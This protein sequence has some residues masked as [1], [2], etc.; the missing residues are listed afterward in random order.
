MDNLLYIVVLFIV[1]MVIAFSASWVYSRYFSK[2]PKSAS[3]AR[4]EAPPA[5]IHGQNLEPDTEYCHLQA[6]YNY[7]PNMKGARVSVTHFDTENRQHEV[8]AEDMIEGKF[9]QLRKQLQ[10]EGWVE[11]YHH[12]NQEGWSYYFTRT[13][14]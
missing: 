13:K 2:S 9:D 12:T 4:R 1:A 7:G 11:S 6:D 10:R 5:W 14:S 8:L 3:P